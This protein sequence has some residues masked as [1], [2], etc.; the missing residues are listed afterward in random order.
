MHPVSKS[1]AA[2]R[3]SRT[4]VGPPR[5]YLGAAL[6]Q[7]VECRLPP[8]VHDI[9]RI[10]PLMPEPRRQAESD[11][12]GLPEVEVVLPAAVRRVARVDLVA[13]GV[14]KL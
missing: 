1:P 7:G 13:L 4:V 12:L 10:H 6:D 8:A 5:G 14:R 2:F 11:L 9:D 3:R